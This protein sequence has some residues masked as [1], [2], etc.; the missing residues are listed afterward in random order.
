MFD[1][2]SEFQALLA[3]AI[4]GHPAV[5][6]VCMTLPTTQYAEPCIRQ[7]DGSGNAARAFAHGY[8]VAQDTNSFL[9]GYAAHAKYW[10][11]LRVAT[12]TA[13]SPY[14]ALTTDPTATG[15][16]ATTTIALMNQMVSTLGRL[17]VWGNNG[18]QNAPPASQSRDYAAMYAA[19]FAAAS[20]ASPVCIAYQTKTLNSFKANRSQ[21]N[22]N[23]PNT[24]QLAVNVKATGVELP[25]GCTYPAAGVDYL[26][27]AAAHRMNVRFGANALRYLG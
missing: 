13:F 21:A 17:A 14:Q 4:G 20:S 27:Q 24:V 5:A 18:F 10:S 11:P 16:D 9:E 25:N 1:A 6:E 23:L 12:Q 15:G 3:A 7:R 8:T 26:S 22:V 19:Q 2:Y